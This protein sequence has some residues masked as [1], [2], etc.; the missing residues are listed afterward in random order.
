MHMSTKFYLVEQW[1]V[2]YIQTLCNRYKRHTSGVLG[3]KAVLYNV[4]LKLFNIQI[5]ALN[6]GKK[7]H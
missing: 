5:L 6:F 7:N 4:V 3:K 1:G 2:L